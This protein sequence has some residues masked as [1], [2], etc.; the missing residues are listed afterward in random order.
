[1]AVET[2][3]GRSQSSREM[4]P[5]AVFYSTAGHGGV[6]LTK[7]RMREFRRVFPNFETFAGG[8]WFEEDQDYAVVILAFADRFSD[9]QV[10]SAVLT[11]RSAARPF[12]LAAPGDPPQVQRYPKWERVVWWLGNSPAGIRCCERGES[13]AESVAEQYE[14]GSMGTTG[15]KGLWWVSMRRVSDDEQVECLMTLEQIYSKRFFTA[16]EVEA[17]R[18]FQPVPVTQSYTDSR[19]MPE[20]SDADSGL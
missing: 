20:P 5:G 11:A 17:H 6:H 9:E 8:P 14:R 18:R 16:E 10:R 4:F 12:N 7:E 1:M 15:D 3:W 2:P 13:F 19:F